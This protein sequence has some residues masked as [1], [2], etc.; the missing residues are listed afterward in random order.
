M[1]LGVGRP[2]GEAFASGRIGVVAWLDPTRLP[3]I[4]VSSWQ[5]KHWGTVRL[6]ALSDVDEEIVWPGPIPLFAVTSFS[7][8][9]ES[10]AARLLA[11]AKGF[12]NVAPPEQRLEVTRLDVSTP[13]VEEP[14]R[15][16]W[17]TAPRDWNA[18]RG[19]AAMAA[20]SVPAMDPW[21][22]VLCASLSLAD[23]G[24][25]AQ[26]LSASWWHEP[27]WRSFGDATRHTT[28]PHLPLW[29]AMVDVLTKVRIRESWR[30]MEILDAVRARV[31]TD[32]GLH[33]AA[34]DSLMDE[35]EAICND[36]R[37]ITVDRFSFDPLGLTLQLL[38]LRPTPDRFVTWLHD[39]RGLPPLAWWTGAMLSGLVCGYRDLDQRFRGTLAARRRLALR[40]WLLAADGAGADS[41]AT[42]PDVTDAAPTWKREPGRLSLFWDGEPWA[43]R[44]E[45]ARGRW[46]AADV[47]RPDLREAAI[48]LAQDLHP[49]CLRRRAHLTDARL[50]LT[51]SGS[52][53]VDVGDDDRQ[54]V[55][56]GDVFLELPRDVAITA[57]LDVDAFR[58]WLTSAG[59]EAR[60]PE[61]PVRPD[62]SPE[63]R[64][65]PEREAVPGLK[66][67]PSFV[68]EAEERELIETV[69]ASPWRPD[70]NRR[71]QHY[72]WAYDYKAR[73]VD[74][75]AYLG[76]LPEWAARLGSRLLAEGL[77]DEPPDQVIVNEY[78]GKQGIGKHVDC[79]PCFRGKIV[80]VS[81]GESWEMFFWAPGDSAKVVR[82][83]D[84]RSA[85]SFGG[86]ARTQW[87]HEIPKRASEPWGRRSRRL[88]LTFR[89]VDAPP[90]RA[91]TET[92]DRRVRTIT[93]PRPGSSEE[94][95]ITIS[96]VIALIRDSADGLDAATAARAL[97]RNTGRGVTEAQLRSLADLAVERG[98][99]RR[100]RR[101]TYRDVRA[102]SSNRQD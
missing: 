78:V 59:I 39:L 83:L 6:S 25:S 74:P 66:V 56:R 62:R 77:L 22:D 93:K 2:R 5:G 1:R 35:T 71:V 33:P 76:P 65:V 70:L 44:A 11:M 3:A 32:H 95:A 98:Q 36:R 18:L 102:R 16:P 48:K 53:E 28:D 82:I 52:V 55:T 99:L 50:S 87:K 79:L 63:Q 14:S 58:T 12:S 24:A 72:G 8:G 37:A 38:L 91:P 67:V 43:E 26:R 13:G 31:C 80:T 85:A 86:E 19:A 40:T 47:C 89:K 81:L 27:P 45:T 46:L 29:R 34:L 88:S 17:L 4:E 15:S 30:P 69:D 64:D 68:S 21:V 94:A 97:S 57:D 60:L 23:D 49:S 90:Q 96:D 42:W 84:R 73:S 10:D 100:T 61:P 54:L 20:W 7:V 51:G 9:S 92:R 75:K 41:R 101:G